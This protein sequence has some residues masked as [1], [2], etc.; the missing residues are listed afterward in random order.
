MPFKTCDSPNKQ[1][2]NCLQFLKLININNDNFK[3]PK[4]IILNN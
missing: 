1:F 2:I 4:A 3:L